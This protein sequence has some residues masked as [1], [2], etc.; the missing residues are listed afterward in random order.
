LQDFFGAVF[1][2]SNDAGFMTGLGM[3]LDGALTA[4]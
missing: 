2:A 4:P 3:V 1:R